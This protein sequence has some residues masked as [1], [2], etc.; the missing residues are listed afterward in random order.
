MVA[1]MDFCCK[2]GMYEDSPMGDAISKQCFLTRRSVLSEGEEKAVHMDAQS[3]RL[4]LLRRSVPLC[5]KHSAELRALIK[6]L[7]CST[8][9]T[10]KLQALGLGAPL[11][12]RTLPPNLSTLSPRLLLRYVESVLRQLQYNY[13]S[14]NYFN[15]RKDRPLGSIMDTAKQILRDQLPIK[16]V[17][18][19][20]LA[21]YLTANHRA[22]DRIPVAFK[23]KLVG[24]NR[25]TK[26]NSKNSNSFSSAT[27]QPQLESDSQQPLRQQQKQ[28]QQQQHFQAQ[29]YR[30]I[31]LILHHKLSNK[32]ASLG[33][34]RRPELASKD[35]LFA[36]LSEVLSEYRRC[37]AKWRH[38]IV[39][40]KL[41]LP[42]E[43]AIHSRAPVC[44]RFCRLDVC[45]NRQ[46][47][48]IN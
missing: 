3:S 8:D 5:P 16:C 44:W 32:F 21:L 25:A 23:T 26:S 34:S 39:S 46:N 27:A 37:Y 47:N 1:S 38:K 20:F 31:V 10:S 12:L 17:E 33:T 35:F 24:M 42:V 41:G 18:A 30:H 22:I 2:A 11:P 45:D 6:A 48:N 43:H 4:L 19:V 9:G 15:I 28:Q 7:N 13:T 14:V 36:S 40:I 29:E